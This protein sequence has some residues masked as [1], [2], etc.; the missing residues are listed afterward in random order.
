MKNLKD[1]M[2]ELIRLLYEKA[3]GEGII[4][5]CSEVTKEDNL[6]LHM[7]TII[8]NK[9]NWEK[10]FY[11]ESLY[12]NYQIGMHIETLADVLL[13]LPVIENKKDEEKD[14]SFL[15]DIGDFNEIK[16]HIVAKVMNFDMNRDYLQD[17]IYLE[18]LDLAVC[19]FIM[20]KKQEDYIS[21]LSLSRNLLS[22]WKLSEEELLEIAVKNM[23]EKLPVQ[24]INMSDMLKNLCKDIG[25]D[26]F[27]EMINPP[28]ESMP[29]YVMTNN[30]KVNGATTILYNEVLRDF[31]DEQNVE[32][33]LILPS[34]LHEVI[35]LPVTEEKDIDEEALN[36]VV[37][38]VNSTVLDES[39]ILSDHV[40]I[41]RKNDNEIECVY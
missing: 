10:R 27:A 11:V 4:I 21:T 34:S 17:K 1:F 3:E 29:L 37:H 31:A 23:E 12:K 33:V 5:Y 28:E 39:E 15:N 26:D 24:I 7:I 25:Q 19:F 22:I 18:Y 30:L 8:R 14:I 13:D 35:L 38:M 2:Y 36:S 9:S 6:K 20:V 16:D 40:Y 32:E 41:Y